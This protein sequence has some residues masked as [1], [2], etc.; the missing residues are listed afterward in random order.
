[1][2]DVEIKSLI[3][4]AVDVEL[5]GHRT[6]P[7]ID[8]A[9]LAGR[10]GPA[11]AVRLWSVP[12]LAASVAVLL[13]VGAMLAITLNRDQRS[14]RV[15]NPAGP[16]PSASLSRSTYP[17]LEAAQRAYAEAVAGAREATEVPG[18]SVGGV[19]ARDAARLKDTGLISGDISSITDP[20]PGKT[21]SFTLSYIAG[22]S[23]DPPMV[24]TT[25]VQDV[26]SGSCAQ[27]FLARPGHSYV[28]RCQAM[29]MAGVTGKGTVTLRTPTGTMGGS[30]NL[31]DPAKYPASPSTSSSPGQA[32][33]AREYALAVAT[34]PEASTVAG[35]VDRPAGPDEQHP[36]DTVGSPD[37][38]VR[39]P[40]PGRSY[41]L[42]LIYVPP[43]DAPA[44][45]V[46][47][48][49]FE[50]VAAGRCAGPFRVRPAHA[51]SIR[52]QVTF[53][54]GAEG[55]AYYKVTGPHGAETT[56]LSLSSP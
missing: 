37:I 30:M 27:P 9:A 49:R 46:L 14:N 35:V 20:E 55:I 53:R 54:A 52:C 48:V 15:S 50:D 10:S 16:T 8:R 19:S 45:S 34:A 28:I 44:V 22:P 17:D 6:A 13:A 26:A 36:G 25:E 23:D 2:N 56:G 29:L 41:R 38:P 7:P 33:A 40:E 12:L 1:V 3:N 11:H 21:Y 51:Y 18:V 5:G 4:S 42:T 39:A 43:Q 47:A 31:T 32:E 24:L